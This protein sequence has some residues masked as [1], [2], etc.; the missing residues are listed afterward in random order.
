MD[1]VSGRERGICQGTHFTKNQTETSDEIKPR[2]RKFV[3]SVQIKVVK[4]ACTSERNQQ[5]GDDNL[6][7]DLK[8]C[9]ADLRRRTCEQR[10]FAKRGL[11]QNV[12]GRSI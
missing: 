1:P 11:E 2:H 5:T 12:N 7:E 4:G 9:V 6:D 8:R 10:R 3:Q